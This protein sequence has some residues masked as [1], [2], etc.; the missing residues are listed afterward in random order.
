MLKG[1]EFTQRSIDSLH[2]QLNDVLVYLDGVVL[3][4]QREEIR[5]RLENLL[6]IVNNNE[7]FK[8]GISRL[9]DE[10]LKKYQRMLR[11][12]FFKL[13]YGKRADYYFGDILESPIFQKVNVSGNSEITENT[14]ATVNE[15]PQNPAL[16]RFIDGITLAADLTPAINALIQTGD[17]DRFIQT[18]AI[19]L[20]SILAGRSA[21]NAVIRNLTRG[22]SEDEIAERIGRTLQVLVNTFAGRLIETMSGGRDE[23]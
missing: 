9:D 2:R 1:R 6:K 15:P 11:E 22:L 7:E 8:E 20:A 3:D 14:T 21:S 5:T 4:P 10:G 23:R 18:T 12:L 16:R 13:T 19:Q 17:W